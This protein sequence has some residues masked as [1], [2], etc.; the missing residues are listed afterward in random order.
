MDP[1]P[2]SQADPPAFDLSGGHTALDLVN[3]L[4]NRFEDDTRVELLTDYGAL[5]RFAQQ[6]QLLEPAQA[7]SLAKSVQSNAAARALR[8]VRELREALATALYGHLEG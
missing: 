1:D 6:T 4:D 7:R 8:S 2:E 5:L 3:T